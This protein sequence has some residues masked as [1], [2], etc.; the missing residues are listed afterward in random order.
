MGYNMSN[1]NIAMNARFLRAACGALLASASLQAQTISTV[2]EDG[3]L[4][5]PQGVTVAPDSSYVVTDSTRNRVLK[6]DPRTQ[7]WITLAGRVEGGS[8]DG[9]GAVAGFNFPKGIVAVNDGFVVADA[10][11]HTIRWIGANG[12]VETLAGSAGQAGNVDGAGGNARFRF[13]SGVAVDRAGLI[14]I[15][16]AKNNAV[17]SLDLNT[18]VVTTLVAASAGLLEP[19]ALAV[20]PSGVLLVADTRN[21][22]IVQVVGNTVTAVAGGPAGAVPDWRDSAVGLDAR[23]NHPRGLVWAGGQAGFLVSDAGNH[24]IR[25]LTLRPLGELTNNYAVR[26]LVGSAGEPGSVDGVGLQARLNFPEGLAK[27]SVEG[28]VLIADSANGALRRLRSALFGAEEVERIVVT[29]PVFEP[30]AGYFPAGQTITVRSV[31]P[32]V[33]YTT[34]DTDP[35]TNSHQV[36]L[37]DGVGQ[38]F[39]KESVRDLTSLRMRAFVYTNASL[40]VS[41]QYVATNE[42][43]FLRDYE[44]GVG[45]T[46]VVP[47]VAVLKTN[48]V[49][50]SLQFRVEVAPAASNIG[51]RGPVSGQF[52]NLSMGVTDFVRVVPPS[53]SLTTKATPSI[54]PYVGEGSVRGLAVSFIGTNANLFVRQFGV[55]ALLAVP[56]PTDAVEGD[57]FELRVLNVSG[58]SDGLDQSVY[59]VPGR[60]ATIEVRNRTYL[61]G[62]SVPSGWYNAGGFGDGVLENSDVN[63]AFYAALGLRLPFTF[64][65]VFDAMDVFPEDSSGSVGGDGE[66][67]FLDWQRV[68]R[69]S[70]QIPGTTNNWLR[71]WS[72]NGVRSTTWTDLGGRPNTPALV[73]TAEQVSSGWVR[74][75]LIGAGTVSRVAAGD[76][77][78]IP[79][80][81]KVAS[82]SQFSG[83]L[84]SIGVESGAGAAALEDPVEFSLAAGVPSGT[85]ARSGLEIVGYGWDLGA[86]N[87]PLTGSNVLGYLEVPI[88]RAAA[89]GSYYTLKFLRADGSPDLETQYNLESVHGEIWVGIDP[90]RAPDGVSDDWKT[91]YFGDDPSGVEFEAEGDA[92][93]DGIIN[94]AEYWAG[95]DPKDP[96]SRIE[97]TIGATGAGGQLVLQWLSAPGRRYAVEWADVLGGTPVWQRMPDIGIGDGRRMELSVAGP[98]GSPRFYRLLVEP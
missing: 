61:V 6:V 84:F 97:L 17:R 86:F 49:L 21:H 88:P 59:L 81:L 66:I 30:N 44:G 69:R 32:S 90:P 26:T 77:V 65:D 5:E 12:T 54:L 96:K 36:N 38:I 67:R 75:A 45:S 22:R 15:A 98:A 95:T 29:P 70:L 16:D 51:T 13:P 52:R 23:F 35:T 39:W 19:T 53:R 79:I 68:L 2:I 94:Q 87:P 48:D 47:I 14:Y 8:A 55:A 63:S 46:V 74:E 50:R 27:D 3:L 4:V 83:L 78:R 20:A 57:R 76:R 37:V 72:T 34:D 11:N 9:P 41:G 93:Q 82:G 62:D 33:Y 24:V 92:D 10:G 1:L 71:S 28:S 43:G 40:V 25:S 64:T 31:V 60:A 85:S 91:A 42:I 89:G 73:L 18:R 58:T 7:T 56:I 80:Y